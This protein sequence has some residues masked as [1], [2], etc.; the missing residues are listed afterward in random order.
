MQS[1]FLN[2]AAK[3]FPDVRH[4]SCFVKVAVAAD[5]KVKSEGQLCERTTRLTSD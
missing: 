4:G 1:Y 3:R 2:A 5:V